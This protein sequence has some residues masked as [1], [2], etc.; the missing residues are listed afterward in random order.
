MGMIGHNQ[1]NR[2]VEG[3]SDD[4]RK[5][6]RNAIIE[7]NDSMTRAAAERELQ[8]ETISDISGALDID[9]KLVRRMSSVYFKA[10]FND[11][12]ESNNNFESFYEE[13]LRKTV[14]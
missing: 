9:K 12:V 8:K 11:E 13:V 1:Q 14:S 2:S 5:R 10:T 6:L 3:L 4:E 7:L